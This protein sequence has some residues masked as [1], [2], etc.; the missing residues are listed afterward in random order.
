MKLEVGEIYI[1]DIKLDKIS[2]VENGTLFVNKDEITK[3]VLEDEK[4]KSVQVEVARP[5]ESVRITPVKDVIEPR[6]KVDGKGGIFPGMISKVDTVGEGKTHVLKGAAVIT[7]GKIVGFQEGIIDMSGPGA[8]YTPFSKLNNLCLVIEPI[9]PIEKHDY[10]AAVRGAGLRVATYLGKLAKD[11]K[12]DNTYSYETKPIFEQASMY[13]NLP[14]VGYVYMLQ[15]QGLLHDTYVYGVDA[16]K[17]VPTFIYPTEI[18]DG[19][20]VSGNCVSACDK[21]TTYHH[22]NNPIIKALYEKHGKE[23]NFMG[24]IITNENVFLADKMRSSDWASKLANYFGLDGVIISEEGF[25]NPD[26]DLIMNCKKAEAFGIKTCIVTDEYAGRDGSSQSLA[27]ADASA[28]AVVTAGN[29]NIVIN[30][31]KMDKI[32]GM[33]DYTDKIAGGFEGSLK[34]DGSIEAELQVITGATNELGFNKFSAIGY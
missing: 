22:L 29:A 14:K 33:L 21:N 34:P 13:P 12:P 8:D 18:M 26:S 1:K 9:E 15:T 4:L 25:G 11:L 31:P 32:I 27:D 23:I 30:L 24:A 2:K 6:V 20:I 10:E 7:C 5:G 28:N 19:A 3:I 16:K 17:I